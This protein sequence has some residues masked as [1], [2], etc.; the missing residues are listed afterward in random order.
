MSFPK[1]SHFLL[2]SLL[3]VTL[4]HGQQ[5]VVT[6]KTGER[7]I[8][9]VSPDSNES[10]LILNSAL[11]GKIEL[12]QAEV[13]RQEPKSE[14]LAAAN[15]PAAEQTR[16]NEVEQSP[17]PIQ[18]SEAEMQVVEEPSFFRKMT[19][20][21]TPESWKGNLRF[22]LDYSNGDSEWS[23]LYTKGNL[24]IDPQRGPNYYR[25]SGSYTYRTT[26]RNG[27]T[28]KSTDRYDGNF[29]YRRDVTGPLFIQNSIAGRV[30]RVKG[31]NHEI[32]ELVGFGFRFNPVEKFEFIFGGSGGVEDFDP[33][34]EDSRSGI[35]TVANAFQELTWRPFE[36]ATLAQEFNYYMEPDEEYKYNYVL[37]A[38]FRYR[39]TDLLGY[40]IS[41]NKD[42]DS[43]VGN[44]NVKEVTRWRHAIVVY[45]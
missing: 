30:D 19:S 13:F 35:H 26:E 41:F 9:E 28:V 29:T 21:Q 3:S 31:I 42:F 7:L 44:G 43:D 24:V 39:L 10:T 25:F 16:S 15:P 8:G 5:T 11:L 17:V 33:E 14:N 34:Y 38:S 1:V 18:A 36:R 40:E 45:F 4:C 20:F 2:I 37:S 12:P 32:Q 23:Q 6:M 22:G 27:D